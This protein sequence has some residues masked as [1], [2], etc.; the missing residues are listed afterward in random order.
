MDDEEL[1]L[2][3]YEKTDTL[4]EE[5]LEDD[6]GVSGIKNKIMSLFSKKSEEEESLDD[7]EDEELEYFDEE[8]EDEEVPAASFAD[9][10][11]FLSNILNK[12]NNDKKSTRSPKKG[13]KKK[14]MSPVSKGI[15]AVVIIGLVIIM[16]LPDDDAINKTTETAN[17][18]KKN[19]PELNTAKPLESKV[20]ETANKEEAAPV[21]GT[22]LDKTQSNELTQKTENLEQTNSEEVHEDVAQIN[23]QEESPN[24]GAVPS[25]TGMEIQSNTN[26]DQENITQEDISDFEKKIEE[27][28]EKDASDTETAKLEDKSEDVKVDESVTTSI[29]ISEDSATDLTKKLLS[30]LE[31]RLKDEKAKQN[32]VEV[33]KPV[34]APS[35]EVRGAGL[36][37]NCSGKHWACI[38]PKAYDIC[39]QNYSWN[40]KN[41]LPIECYPFA[42]VEDNF[43]CATVQQEK[44]D[45]IADTSFCK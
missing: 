30:D 24:E 16:T 9:K 5:E 26:T 8:E 6:S 38:E 45:S 40:S 35:Y 36:V 31:N 4:T 23:P 11:P 42:D 2:E 33:L 10:L 17:I 22:D 20:Q 13:K 14:E 28:E 7:D 44:I 32:E 27:T 39:R 18:T 29:D 3:E 15:Y 43:D 34:S 1:L 37:Y 19:G 41:K 25:D 12:K 21:P